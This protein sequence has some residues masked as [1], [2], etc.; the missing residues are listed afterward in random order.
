MPLSRQ[1]DPAAQ[2]VEV[3]TS[4]HLTLDELELGNVTLCLTAAPGQGQGSPHGRG[5][6]LKGGGK[7]LYG[8]E[9]A[10]TGR[11]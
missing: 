2:S 3:S 6:L 11:F 4:V 8:C 7:G 1:Q 9:A 5:L 10:T